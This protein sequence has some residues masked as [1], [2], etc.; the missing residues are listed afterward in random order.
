MLTRLKHF[1]AQ[2][3]RIK[4]IHTNFFSNSRQI[5]RIFLQSNKLET[6][7]EQF[8][9]FVDLSMVDLR[10]NSDF[11]DYK[12]MD[13]NESLSKETVCEND[14]LQ[15][16]IEWKNKFKN[17]SINK[18]LELKT[19]S[20]GPCALNEAIRM[21]SAQR[22]FQNCVWDYENDKKLSNAEAVGN[23][24]I[25]RR[26]EEQHRTEYDA[27]VLKQAEMNYQLKQI[28]QTCYS[29]SNSTINEL[30]MTLNTRTMCYANK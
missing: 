2:H 7:D 14:N 26:I 10:G 22:Q 21:C 9:Q 25:P 3:N 13:Q 12:I 23:C 5:E 11:C 28:L 4:Q 20:V 6:L 16:E 29:A 19:T 24:T 30:A 18:A 8:D 1:Y 17:C 15:V 27:C